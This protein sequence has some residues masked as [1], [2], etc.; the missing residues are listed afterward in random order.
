MFMWNNKGGWSIKALEIEKDINIL[1]HQYTGSKY[2]GQVFS[3]LH[4]SLL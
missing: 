4:K 2:L 1:S 3:G